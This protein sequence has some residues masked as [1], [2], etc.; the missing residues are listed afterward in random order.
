[1][2][3]IALRERCKVV[4]KSENFQVAALSTQAK[5]NWMEMQI[6]HEARKRI[7]L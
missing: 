7:Y 4:Y 1:M 3:A 2:V 5:K 6:V